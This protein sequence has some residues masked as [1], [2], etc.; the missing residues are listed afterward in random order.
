M[1]EAQR[2][3]I[4]NLC[5]DGLGYKRIAALLE[6]PESTVKSYCRRH[7]IERRDIARQIV[8][9]DTCRECGARLYN[10]K[11]HRQRVFCSAECRNEYWRKHTAERKNLVESVC[12]CCGKSVMDYAFRK[13]KYCSLECYRK[14]RW[15]T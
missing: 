2:D 15:G 5:R 11:G 3:Q 6:L 13:R 1:T 9:M 14:A 8:N 7:G 4:R 12:Q 10:T